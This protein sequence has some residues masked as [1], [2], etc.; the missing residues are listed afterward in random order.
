MTCERTCYIPLGVGAFVILLIVIVTCLLACYI[1][2]KKLAE[3]RR[4]RLLRAMLE[5]TN[6]SRTSSRR[7]SFTMSNRGY[8]AVSLFDL[9]TPPPT[10]PSTDNN[11]VT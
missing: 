2:K 7:S 6:A 11:G 3:H 8:Q 9:Y 1:H 4:L 5:R 10:P